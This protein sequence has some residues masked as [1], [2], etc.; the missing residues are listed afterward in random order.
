MIQIYRVDSMRVPWGI[1][2]MMAMGSIFLGSHAAAQNVITDQVAITSGQGKLF[3]LTPGEGIS[4]EILASGED[5][6]VIETKGVTG[7]VQ[8][9]TRLLGFSGRL[10]RWVEL[11]LATGEQI[12]KWKVTSRMVVV[13]GRKA[14]YGFQSDRGR[15]KRE[16]WGAGE[17]LKNSAVKAHIAVMVTNRR[18]LGFSAFTGGFFPQDLPAGNQ[19]QEIEINDNVVILHLSGFMLVFRSG[20]AIWAELP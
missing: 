18:A 2:M 9:S 7:F 13:Q 5:V 16:P 12:I 15:W 1:V 19:I 10:N 3:G 4:R 20:L 6:L 14:A 17:S 8:T 11:T